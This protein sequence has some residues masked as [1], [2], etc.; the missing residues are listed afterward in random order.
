MIGQSL[1]DAEPNG[2]DQMSRNVTFGL[3]I[4]AYDND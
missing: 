2:M 1:Q 4:D 3:D